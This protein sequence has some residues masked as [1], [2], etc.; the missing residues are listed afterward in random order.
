M[1]DFLL[2]LLAEIVLSPCTASHP[3]PLLYVTNRNE[4]LPGGDTITVYSPYH[5]MSPADASSLDSESAHAVTG[6]DNTSKASFR[7][8]DS[9]ATGL[10]HL[11]SIALGG[12]DSRYL[13]AGGVHG[14][15]AKIFERNGTSLR[16]VAKVDIEKPACFVWL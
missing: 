16:E 3:L 1:S 13:I 14:R 8:L 15:R 2:W 12:P 6:Q 11:R 10:Q 4:A 7:Y 5:G 9:I